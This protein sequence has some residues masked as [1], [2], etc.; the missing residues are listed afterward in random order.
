MRLTH[1]FQNQFRGAGKTRSTYGSEI[2]SCML[3]R[4]PNIYLIVAPHF[5]CNLSP[6][7][8]KLRTSYRMSE[9]PIAVFTPLLHTERLTMRLVDL[10]K[11]IGVLAETMNVCL[12]EADGF[13]WTVEKAK[14]L[15]K[16]LTLSPRNCLGLKAP[17]PA[18]SS[19]LCKLK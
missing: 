2:S 16:N 18:V 12:R 19:S 5:D 3:M 10:E 14:R 4:I 15:F 13:D 7:S 1:N 11:D 8:I 9:P 6:L 17:G